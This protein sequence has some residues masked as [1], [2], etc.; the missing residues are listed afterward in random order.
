M[1]TTYNGELAIYAPDP[2]FVANVLARSDAQ[3]VIYGH[4]GFG[5]HLLLND[6]QPRYITFLRDPTRRILSFFAH[7]AREPR[8]RLYPAISNGLTLKAAISGHLAPELN[9]YVTRI[10][11]AGIGLVQALR[12]NPAALRLAA[13][14][15]NGLGHG[16]TGPYDQILH[17]AHYQTA[18]EHLDRY[19][20]FVGIAERMPESLARL[21]RIMNWN[22]PNQADVV[23][24]AAPG[25]HPPIDG[26]TQE[27]IQKY[28]ALDIDL[29]AHCMTNRFATSQLIP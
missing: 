8:S 20:A 15:W 4:Y 3:T 27:L 2:G 29:Y 1:I 12:T 13:G 25:S 26:E 10:L 28:N 9:N 22:A 17:R 14:S 18:L 16:P 6:D 5:V 21:A 24:N 7:Q 23:L 19:F 11:I